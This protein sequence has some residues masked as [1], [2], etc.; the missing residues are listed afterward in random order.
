MT[1]PDDDRERLRQTFN[2][3]ANQAAEIE[4]SGLFEAVH[5][6]HF[7]WERVYDAENY[8]DLLNTFS[9]HIAMEYWKRDRLPRGDRLRL[10]RRPDNSVRHHWGAV[11]PI[12]RRRD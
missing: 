10:G 4:A 8:V 3:A 12:A 11:L 7:D 1:T 6:R 9:G 5:I 2:S